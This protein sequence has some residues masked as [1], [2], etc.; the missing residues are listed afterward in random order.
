MGLW[1]R[2]ERSCGLGRRAV[3]GHTAT[4]DQIVTATGFRPVHSIAS[5]LRLDLD[6]VL[7][8]TRA[9]APLIN[10][11]EPSCG[12]VPPH[13]EAELAHQEPGY[14]AAGI[15]SYRCTLTFLMATGYQQV[16]GITGFLDGDLQGAREAWRELPQTGVCSTDQVEEPQPS[17]GCSSKDAS[18]PAASRG[19]TIGIN[20]GLPGKPMQLAGPGGGPECCGS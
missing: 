8:A 1:R 20:G 10:P 7:E 6:P 19:L 9:L 3:D 15:K 2:P 17:G 11:N 14:H 16:R 18:Q 12:T 4:A 13:C 5:Q